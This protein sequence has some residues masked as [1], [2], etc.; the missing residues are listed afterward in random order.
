MR[1][2]IAV[3]RRRAAGPVNRTGTLHARGHERNHVARA[4]KAAASQE[5]AGVLD[6]Q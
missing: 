1:R 2:P 4:Q 3:P 5:T 6:E